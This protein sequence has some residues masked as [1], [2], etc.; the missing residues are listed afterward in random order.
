[1]AAR[2]DSA[3]EYLSRTTGLLTNS[4]AYTVMQLVR[5]PTGTQSN[6]FFFATGSHPTTPGPSAYERSDYLF[7]TGG[8]VSFRSGTFVS[9]SGAETNSGDE[10]S[11][12]TWYW[13]ILRRTSST[14]ITFGY[15][16]IGGSI[17]WDTGSTQDASGRAAAA[18]ELIGALDTGGTTNFD[19]EHFK[20]WSTNL[21][22]SELNTE[23]L[24][25]NPQRSANLLTYTPFDSTLTS[26]TGTS[27]TATGTVGFVAGS[28]IQTSGGAF[29][30]TA[31][32][33]SFTETGVAA[34]LIKANNITGA[35]AT[36]TLTGIAANLNYNGAPTNYTLTAQL[37]QF[38]QNGYDV[39][40]TYS[41]AN[42]F[43][44]DRVTGNE[45]Y[46]IEW[47]QTSGGPYPNTSDNTTNDET[48]TLLLPYRTTWYVRVAALVGGVPQDYTAERVITSGIPD[49]NPDVGSF[50]LTG[51]ANT[52]TVGKVLTAT[53]RSYTEAGIAANLVKT[54]VL[55]LSVGSYTFTG[56]DAALVY[57]PSGTTYI[58]SAETGNIVYTGI[59]NSL[60]V[61]YG[62]VAD[63]ISYTLTASNATLFY[64][65]SSTGSSGSIIPGLRM[66]GD[67]FQWRVT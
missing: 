37:G 2:L 49:L 61:G 48:I 32:T 26:T 3:S 67:L 54:S 19:V 1:M 58:L 25:G 23:I 62:I 14:G 51:I 60:L 36:F 46:R 55:P 38:I 7:M 31:D 30:L 28:S 40:L 16:P 47:G 52:L 12:N 43:T 9:G 24:W 56:N 44:W 59:N 20:A 18:A 11:E 63:T 29:T 22:D 42:Y 65:L 50:T 13:V 5:Q 27:W 41:V 57:T 4:S 39:T 34:G 66:K 33:V 35:T 6:C 17:T 45:G 21:S 10:L 8:G 15:A 53:S 64:S